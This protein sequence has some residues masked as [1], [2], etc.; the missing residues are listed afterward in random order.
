VPSASILPTPG[1]IRAA[2]ARLAPHI[3]RTPLV[4]S[5]GLSNFLGGEV[6]LKLESEQVTGSFKIRG[7][8]N[9]LGS[10]D[11]ATQ[12]R[13]VVTA[14]S[15]NH[16][17]GI[18]A[19]ARQL[20]IEATVFVPA[21]TPAVKRNKIAALGATVNTS[22]EHYDAAELLARA[23]AATLGATFV[24]AS[25]GN[26]LLAGQ[27]TVALEV[28]DELPELRTLVV[29][30]GGGGLV[31]GIAGWLRA[32]SPAVRIVGAQG[33]RTNAMALAMATGKPAEIP[34]RP[35]LSDGLAG[36]VDAAGLA[37][38][39]A[40]MDQITVVTEE[41]LADAIAFLWIEEGLKVE[42]AG[43]AA[44]AAVLSGRV[45]QVAFPVAIIVT[46]GNIDDARHRAVLDASYRSAEA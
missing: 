38:G 17:L 18:A 41:D 30:V 22:A 4:R 9:A 31:A 10:L 6:R 7:A 15:G 39:R 3:R 29:A 46:G 32:Q 5:E 40:A 1:D 27:G 14:S 45:E 16:G 12:A 2:A 19:A 35:T 11:T 28:L 34:D 24:H 33:E 44:V 25:T 26:A 20:G 8:T 13:G 42:G 37:Q 43:A 23:H 21:S 36:M